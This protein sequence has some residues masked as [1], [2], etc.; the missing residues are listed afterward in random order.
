MG[1]RMAKTKK[2]RVII[3]LIILLLLVMYHNSNKEYDEEKHYCTKILYSWSFTE[4]REP[5]INL[6]HIDIKYCQDG[7]CGRMPLVK[8]KCTD[9]RMR[10]KFLDKD[11]E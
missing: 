8:I 2:D 5:Y 6:T 11:Q 7:V 3:T 1:A 4:P 9:W 10:N